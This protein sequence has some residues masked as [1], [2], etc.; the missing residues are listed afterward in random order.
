LLNTDRSS[1]TLFNQPSETRLIV[2][3]A[4]DAL[5]DASDTWH[6]LAF[7]YD[8]DGLQLSHYVDGVRQLLPA[9]CE[10]KS[11]APGDEDYLS[12]GRDGLWKRPLPGRLDELRVSD[13]Q[14]YRENFT[15]PESFSKYN[16]ATYEPP[17]LQAG[18]PLLFAGG[19]SAD[20]VVPLGSRKYLF[21]DDAIVAENDNVTF[22]VN[23]PR[24]AEKCSTKLQPTLSSGMMAM[25]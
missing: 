5:S 7:V 23:P 15:P 24:L 13:D 9:K 14:I 8:A 4:P 1:F 22:V 19:R 6:H 16:R 20:K 21:I 3:S 18:P 2:P 12:I 17:K 10:L 25:V 11:L